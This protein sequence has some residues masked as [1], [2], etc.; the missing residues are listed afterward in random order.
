MA[1]F[2]SLVLLPVMRPSAHG[3]CVSEPLCVWAVPAMKF[4]KDRSVREQL[5]RAFVTRAGE[6][7]EPL[8]DQILALKQEQAKILVRR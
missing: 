8:I 7:N 6:A 1:C 5:Y 3:P 4:I 2:S